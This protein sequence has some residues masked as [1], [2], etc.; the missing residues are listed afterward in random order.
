MQTMRTLIAAAMA[1]MA[2]GAAG[3]G[4]ASEAG[5]GRLFAALQGGGMRG[6]YVSTWDGQRV[7]AAAMR[8]VW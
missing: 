8:Q 2:L 5:A 4:A 3:G 6:G 1:W 7:S